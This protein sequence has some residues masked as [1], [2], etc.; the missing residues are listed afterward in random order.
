MMSNRFLVSAPDAIEQEIKSI[1]FEDI[2]K[3]S[4]ILFEVIQDHFG[5]NTTVPTSGK[6][7]RPMLCLLAAQAG[8]LNW[9]KALPAAAAIEIIHNYSLIHDDIEDQ[10]KIR[11]NRP[12]A[13]VKFGVPQAIN[14]GDALLAAGINSVFRLE[15]DFSEGQKELVLRKL[16]QAVIILTKGQSLDLE[17]SFHQIIS[18]SDY[19]LMISEKTAA[20]I[21]TSVSIGAILAGF[22][23]E[24][25]GRLEA[26]G[27]AVGMAFQI[28]D[29]WL[30]IWGDS[31]K[32]GKS[33]A[34]DLLAHKMS[35]PVIM[36]LNEGQTFNK[37]WLKNTISSTNVNKAVDLLEKDGIKELAGQAEK[38]WW[39]SASNAI[40]PLLKNYPQ[41]LLLVEYSESLRNRDH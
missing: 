40:E 26:Y 25:I 23:S 24:K 18:T 29:D 9:K 12:T 10:D 34:N 38:N 11:H 36:G 28:Q 33:T 2:G 3:S 21:K 8:G 27:N 14:A 30:G 41:L 35:L 20:L 37:F 22:S 6:K 19:E 5:W 39:Q 13:W 31:K 16:I 1:V 17:N 32:T 7:M 15:N 4:P